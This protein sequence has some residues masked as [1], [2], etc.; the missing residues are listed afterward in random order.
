[1][2]LIKLYIIFYIIKKNNFIRYCPPPLTPTP[3][4]PAS[5][6]W[7]SPVLGCI[8]FTRPRASLPIDVQLGH[9][10]DRTLI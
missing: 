8:I 4:T 1:M 10:A 9:S 2:F 3:T 5:W 6:P 7:H